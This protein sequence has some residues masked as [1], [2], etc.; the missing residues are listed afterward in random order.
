MNAIALL[1]NSAIDF[2]IK[3]KIMFGDCWLVGH[4]L[5]GASVQLIAAICDMPGVTFNAP[6]VLNLLNQMSSRIGTRIVGSVGG[7]AMSLLTN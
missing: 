7:G 4:S 3:I 2:T 5:G 1:L 6:G